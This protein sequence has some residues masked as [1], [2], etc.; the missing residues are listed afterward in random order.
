MT[1]YLQAARLTLIGIPLA[2]LGLVAL[3]PFVDWALLEPQR[4][5]RERRK[6]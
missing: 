2:V 6:P 4:R 3:I 5:E 1:P